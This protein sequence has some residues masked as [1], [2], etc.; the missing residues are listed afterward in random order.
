[1]A[2][3]EQNV[4]STIHHVP[5]C[6]NDDVRLFQGVTATLPCLD[7]AIPSQQPTGHAAQETWNTHCLSGANKW[8]HVIGLA[9]GTHMRVIT[10]RLPSTAEDRVQYHPDSLSLCILV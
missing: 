4:C 1:M 5:T 10:E 3:L 2:I 7:G 6:E 8:L 9:H